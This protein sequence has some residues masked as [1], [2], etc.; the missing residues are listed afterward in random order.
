MAAVIDPGLRGGVH[1]APRYQPLVP[2]AIALVAGILL[3][4]YV[5]GSAAVWCV[6]A[7]VAAGAWLLLRIL[8]HSDRRLL[9]A[10]LVLVAA[11]GAAWYHAS[12]DSPPDDVARLSA[13]AARLVTIEGILVR[14][15]RQSS[16]PSEVFLPTVAFYTHSTMAVE[17]ERVRVGETWYNVSGCVQTVVRQPQPRGGAPVRLGDRVQIVGILLPGGRPANP[18]SFDVT[19]YLQTQGIRGYLMTH[20]WDA[21]RIIQPAAD[22]PRALVGVLQRWAVDRLEALPTEEGRGVVAAMLFGRRDMLDFDTA[23]ADGEDLQH[24]FLATGTVHYMAVSG[25]NVALVV[26][27]ILVLLRLLGAGRRVTAVLVAAVVLVFLLMTELEPPVLRASI[28]FWVLCI[29]WLW[30]RE[31]SAANTLAAA[32]IVV[33]VVQPGDVFSAS[34]QLSFLAVLG[35]MFVVGRLEK[36]LLGRLLSWQ[37]LRGKPGGG[38][39]YGK[40]LRG[41]FMVSVAATLITAPLIAGKFHIF[42][43]TSPVASAVLL[44]LVFVLTV[45]GMV[46]VSLGW[47]HPLLDAVLAI[48]LDW[49]GRVVA[50]VVK[51][52]AHIPGSYMYVGAVSPVWIFAAYA[53]LALWVW[54]DRVHFSRRRVAIIAMMVAA[55]FFWTGGHRARHSCGPRSWRSATATRLSLN[56]PTAGRCSMTLARRSRTSRPPSR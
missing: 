52:M 18:G 43:W 48:P 42:A 54:R 7:V 16:P 49:M 32:V 27:P 34:F 3:G 56:F 28:L 30:G 24:A 50:I 1:P 45:F 13:A 36:D 35:M 29:G 6:A 17:C 26:A 12:T 14:S 39:L 41:M 23:Q 31:P 33:L 46:Q 47:I 38:F 5:G 4:E 10:F 19:A 20:T 11:T 15:P 53:I 22:R 21:V 37:Q 44:P 55:A 40:V 2:V 51:G 8:R 25:F 9:V